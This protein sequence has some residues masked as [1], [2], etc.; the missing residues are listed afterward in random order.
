MSG[1]RTFEISRQLLG[2]EQASLEARRWWKELETLNRNRSELVGKLTHQ[3]LK[4]KAT[5]DDFY[6]A[7]HHSARL[8]VRENLR[9]L[10]I[11]FQDCSDAPSTRSQNYK[12]GKL[13]SPAIH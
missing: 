4:R 7:C 9:F 2:W 1:E 10:D 13:E 3:L 12:N 5:I 8:G 6:L 11:M